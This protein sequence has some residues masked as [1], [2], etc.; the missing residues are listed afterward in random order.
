MSTRYYTKNVILIAIYNLPAIC[1][2]NENK[3]GNS[4]EAH[5]GRHKPV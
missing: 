5:T 1:Y 3:E 4:Y 2:T